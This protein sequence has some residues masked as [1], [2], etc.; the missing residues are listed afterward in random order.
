[1]IA[2]QTSAMLQAGGL[3]AGAELGLSGPDPSKLKPYVMAL[4]NVGKV[5]EKQE[6]AKA[7]SGLSHLISSAASMVPVELSTSPNDDISNKRGYESMAQGDVA[8]ENEKR[9]IR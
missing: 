8:S 3:N 1:M 2:G 7:A 5:E 4:L 6:F 9:K